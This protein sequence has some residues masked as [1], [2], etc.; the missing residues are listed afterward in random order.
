LDRRRKSFTGIGAGFQ[1]SSIRGG[2]KEEE[3][4]E[5]E[6]MQME[7]TAMGSMERGGEEGRVAGGQGLRV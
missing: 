5:D 1:E 3:E 6:E 7:T 4:E 2:G